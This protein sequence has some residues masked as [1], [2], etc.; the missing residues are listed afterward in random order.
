[1]AASHIDA[2]ADGDD[3]SPID[4]WAAEAGDDAAE[5]AQH[6]DAW[7]DEA[8]AAAVWAEDAQQL[9]AWAAEAGDPAAHDRAGALRKT[10]KSWTD[11]LRDIVAPLRRWARR[12]PQEAVAPPLPPGPPALL[13][14]G[15]DV[16]M[17]SDM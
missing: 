11:S 10:R 16:F 14:D 6:L 4:A 9:D 1:M 7:A 8:D 17:P 2:W 13:D 12:R 15:F 3:I 5:D